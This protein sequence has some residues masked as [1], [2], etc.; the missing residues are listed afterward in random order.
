MAQS[1]VRAF[2]LQSLSSTRRVACCKVGLDRPLIRTVFVAD[3][4]RSATVSR[5]R[6]SADRGSPGDAPTAG[7][8]EICGRGGRAS[9]EGDI[10]KC[11]SDPGKLG[12]LCVSSYFPYSMMAIHY[13]PLGPFVHGQCGWEHQLRPRAQPTGPTQAN[14][15]CRDGLAYN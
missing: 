2:G 4:F 6:R 8:W 7:E 10:V 13:V 1:S 11:A 3:L 14:L 12:S 9:V 15:P 5:A